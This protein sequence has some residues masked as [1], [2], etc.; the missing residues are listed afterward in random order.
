MCAG[1]IT[2]DVR[3]GHFS[4]ANLIF[5]LE[6]NLTDMN[7]SQI[8]NTNIHH[9]VTHRKRS[10]DLQCGRSELAGAQ[11]AVLRVHKL[12]AKVVENA[13]AQ[14]LTPPVGLQ[15]WKILQSAFVAE[16]VDVAAVRA[17]G[18]ERNTGHCG[19]EWRLSKVRSNYN[20]FVTFF[21]LFISCDLFWLTF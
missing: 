15:V 10:G 2:I 21:T 3:I 7:H 8:A 9:K 13:A 14:A 5:L 17:V 16:T 18:H 20:V 11:A 6:K 19:V 1:R 4:N 12:E